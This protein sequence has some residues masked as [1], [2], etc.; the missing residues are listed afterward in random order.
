MNPPAS[1]RGGILKSADELL[2]AKRFSYQRGAAMLLE[3]L[4]AQRA[5]NETPQD[6]EQALA[7]GAKA[8]IE[9]ERAAGADEAPETD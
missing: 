4:E 6:Y 7:D 9:F 2:E 3:L 8:K 1:S 5:A